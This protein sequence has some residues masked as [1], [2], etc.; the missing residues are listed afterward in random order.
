VLGWLGLLLGLSAIM[1]GLAT[2][3]FCA[4]RRTI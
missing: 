2:W 4:Y 1:A 3:A